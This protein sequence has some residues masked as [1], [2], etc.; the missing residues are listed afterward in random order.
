MAITL[1]DSFCVDR[2]RDEFLELMRSGALDI[3]FANR[4]EAL[5][6][7][8]TSDFETAVGCLQRDVAL[9]IIT[10]SAEGSLIVSRDRRVHVPAA[11]IEKIVDLTG[12]GDL[13]A[14]GFLYGLSR[15]Y[16]HEDCGRFGSLA[17]AEVISH[18]GA[19]PQ[20]SLRQR[21]DQEGLA[22]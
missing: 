10:M 18:V 21:A 11:P 2:F 7:Y 14:A 9:A 19:R 22:A 20:E 5:S 16:P 8:Q 12:A 3:V 17:A 1:S 15:G 4:H 13:Y 6:L